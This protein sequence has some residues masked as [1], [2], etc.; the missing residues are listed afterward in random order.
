MLYC[1]MKGGLFM[2]GKHH[3]TVNTAVGIVAMASLSAGIEQGTSLLG[4]WSR[5]G[6]GVL[7]PEQVSLSFSSGFI[8]QTFVYLFGAGFFF[9]A[10]SL[11]PDI[12]SEDSTF[13]KHF[14]LPVK[15]RTWTH[16]IWPCIL[17]GLLAIPTP[18][19][20]WLLFGYLL[21]IAGDAVSAAGVCFSYPF[22]KY[23]EYPSGAFVAP[24]HKCK[25][26]RTRDKSEKRFVI[27]MVLC[28][29]LISALCWRGFVNFASWVL[30]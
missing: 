10:G 24:G 19:F 29:V 12:D 8:F 27:I 18:W 7:V 5:A 16:S 23:R 14:H 9:W 1:R 30:A 17:I 15:H 4:R 13:G 26:Y 20:R 22:K 25:L 3:V 6:L 28:S 11:L 2:M 21:H